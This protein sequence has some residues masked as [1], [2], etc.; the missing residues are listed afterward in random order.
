MCATPGPL[1]S[2][3]LLTARMKLFWESTAIAVLSK[4]GVVVSPSFG[5]TGAGLPPESKLRLNPTAT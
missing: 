1:K 4:S 2:D 5:I 3:E